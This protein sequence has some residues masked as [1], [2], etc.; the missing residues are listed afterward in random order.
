MPCIQAQN[1]AMKETQ[2]EGENAAKKLLPGLKKRILNQDTLGFS[3]DDLLPMADKGK[4][5]DRNAAK[6]AYVR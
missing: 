2:K 5:F 1:P 4:Q 6:N 3:D